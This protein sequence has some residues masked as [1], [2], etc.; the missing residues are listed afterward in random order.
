MELIF[1]FFTFISIFVPACLSEGVQNRA[2]TV[3]R[4]S[5]SAADAALHT[6]AAKRRGQL[7]TKHQVRPAAAFVD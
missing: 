6:R 7:G 2:G 4:Q 1:I 3:S 5:V